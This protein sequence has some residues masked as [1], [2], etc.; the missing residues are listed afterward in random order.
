MEREFINKLMELKGEVFG[1]MERG[2]NGL[3]NELL[4][5][6]LSIIKWNFFHSFLFAFK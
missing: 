3:M 5:Y 6:K 1:M 4:S 2:L